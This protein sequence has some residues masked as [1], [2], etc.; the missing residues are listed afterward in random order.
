MKAFY[1]PWCFLMI[2]RVLY[3]HLVRLNSWN[4]LLGSQ[5]PLPIGGQSN[6]MRRGFSSTRLFLD[7]HVHLRQ[8]M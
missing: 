1:T 7:V 2:L 3:S 6:G 5:G 8:I 4:L